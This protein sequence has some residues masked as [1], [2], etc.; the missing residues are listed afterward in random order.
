MTATPAALAVEAQTTMDMT[1]R[2]SEPRPAGADALAGAYTEFRA[3]LLAFLGS[4]LGDRATAED[5][6]QEVFVKA[7]DALDRG[8]RPANLPAWLRTI[9]ANALTDHYRRSRPTADLPPDLAESEPARSRA[10]RE[11][12]ECLMPFID[13]LPEIYREVM[14]PTVIEGRTTSALARELGLSPSAIKSR[15]SRGRAM[16]RSAI[17][18]CCHVE[19]VASGETL[20]YRRRRD[21]DLR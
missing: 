12:A 8:A 4:K 15:L 17:L 10:E 19:A 3:G 21:I 1:T 2:Q 20:E 9:A 18:D 16:L 5:L 7:L 6:L 11:M 13:G 14:R